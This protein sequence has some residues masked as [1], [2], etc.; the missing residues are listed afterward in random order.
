MPGPRA[1]LLDVF[2]TL[3]TVDFAATAQ[4]LTA[5]S[6]LTQDELDRG[7]RAQGDQI[8]TGAVTL[9]EAFA[10]ALR[11]AD[12]TP[13]E[14]HDLVRLDL[15]LLQAHAK[16]Y[17]DVIPCLQEVRRH[18]VSIALVSNCAANTGPLLDSLGLVPLVDHITLSCDVGV[19]KPDAAIYLATLD[20]LGVAPT[21]ALFV[22]DKAAY[23]AGA[24][25]IGMTAIRIDRHSDD[26]RAVRSLRDVLAMMI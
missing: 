18:G 25:A 22:D 4:G 2:N 12:R 21:D 26:P 11:L 15:E 20:A 24:E 7:F 23:C 14:A 1:V 8:M 13:R 3:L 9:Q 10:T 17:D 5:A 16:L 6:G 19:A